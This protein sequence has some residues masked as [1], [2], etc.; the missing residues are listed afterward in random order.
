MNGRQRGLSQIFG[1]N[2]MLTIGREIPL[3]NLWNAQMI[4]N[5]IP[6]R[7]KRQSKDHF[8][9]RH[10]EAWMIVQAV[11]RYLRYPLGYRDLE[12]MF[13]ERGLRSTKARST[14]GFWPA[15]R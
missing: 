2:R 3:Q 8:K 1:L 10:F 15:R 14:A 6:E 4:L 11:A 12:E 9:W 5:A 7:L 13:W